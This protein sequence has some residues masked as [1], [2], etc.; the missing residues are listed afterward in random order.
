M[1]L[2]YSQF[3]GK[4]IYDKPGILGCTLFRQAHISKKVS[5]RSE[6]GKY[7]NETP[8]YFGY[9]LQQILE[10][11][12]QNQNNGHFIPSGNLT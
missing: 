4:H 11:D 12:L 9:H 10:S 6:V 5:R 3:K 7:P 2:Q 8:N 1:Y